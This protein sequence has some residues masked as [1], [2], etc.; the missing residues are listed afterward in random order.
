MSLNEVLKLPSELSPEL[1][2]IVQRALHF[3]P[4]LGQDQVHNL[5]MP[6]VACLR[7]EEEL[8]QRAPAVPSGIQGIGGRPVSS[9]GHV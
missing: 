5:L 8:Q 2:I 6:D 1:L 4:V 3:V 9:S 7:G